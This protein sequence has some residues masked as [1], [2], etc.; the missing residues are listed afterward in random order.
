MTLIY[1]DQKKLNLGPFLSSSVVRFC[2]FV[3]S[4]ASLLRET[5]RIGAEVGASF[6]RRQLLKPPKYK[7]LG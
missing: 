5:T 6:F 1:T 4:G 2:F 3:Q 7:M